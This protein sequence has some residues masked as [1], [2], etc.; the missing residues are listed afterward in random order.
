MSS[1]DRNLPTFS[2][3]AA[4]LPRQPSG[5]QYNH[6]PP[7]MTQYRD[8][9][10]SSSSDHPSPVTASE[11][12]DGSTW[13]PASSRHSSVSA[14]AGVTLQTIRTRKRASSRGHQDGQKVAQ[15]KVKEKLNRKVQSIALQT[16]EDLHGCFI[17]WTPITAQSNSNGTSSGLQ[18]KK[19]E[20]LAVDTAILARLYSD[21]IQQ[22]LLA[23]G[24]AASYA[25]K[26]RA[27]TTAALNDPSVVDNWTS[28]NTDHDACA[29]DGKSK[30]CLA[31]GTPDFVKCRKAHCDAIYQARLRQCEAKIAR[32]NPQ[33]TKVHPLPQRSANSSTCRR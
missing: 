21:S 17:G 30:R 29:P 20:V 19:E 25:A 4:T 11:D 2:N 28:D 13:T 23:G 18:S 8:E 14:P 26:M 24:S 33:A 27:Y 9:Y 1:I 5:A 16:H 6:L 10:T 12:S 32:S 22:N 15:K 31:H 7:V 3:L